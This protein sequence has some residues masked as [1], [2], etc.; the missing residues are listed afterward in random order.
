[1]VD[2]LSGVGFGFPALKA[3]HVPGVVVKKQGSDAPSHG[4]W[5]TPFKLLS[6]QQLLTASIFMPMEQDIL[7]AES[8]I[9]SFGLPSCYSIRPWD[10]EWAASSFLNCFA[11]WF[12]SPELAHQAITSMIEA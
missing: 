10:V 2:L 12:P 1:M 5:Y 7:F 4:I 3:I 9:N 11:V 6:G 8:Y